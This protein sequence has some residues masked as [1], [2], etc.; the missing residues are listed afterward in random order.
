MTDYVK[1]IVCVLL[2]LLSTSCICLIKVKDFDEF[3]PE[4]KYAIYEDSQNPV[5]AFDKT[6]KTYIVRSKMVE[7]SLYDRQYIEEIIKWKKRNGVQ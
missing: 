3:P 4:P 7:N 2:T 5:I 1:I 6:N